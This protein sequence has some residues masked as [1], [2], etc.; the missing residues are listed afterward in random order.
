MAKKTLHDLD[1]SGK[2]VLLRVDFNVPVNSDREITDDNRIVA[3]LPTIEALLAKG[4]AVILV[5]HFG[6]PKG[7]PEDKY[8]LDVVAAKLGTLLKVPFI[9]CPEFVGDIA[10]QAAAELLPGQVLLLENSRFHP[11]EEKNAPELAKQLASYADIFVNDAFGAAHRAHATTVGVASYLPAVSGL[12][13]KRELDFLE[14]IMIKKPGHKTMAIIGG[15]KVSDKIAVLKNLLSL[16]DVLLI[17]GGMANTFLLSQGMEMGSSLVEPDCAGIA[18]EI[19]HLAE[20][21]HV[22]IVLPVDLIIA[23]EVKADSPVLIVNTEAGIP[24]TYKALDIGPASIQHFCSV[25]TEADTIVWN[26]PVGV[27]EIAEFATGSKEI[28]KT[29][30][31]SKAIT[32]IGGGDTAAAVSVA[33]YASSMSHVS[34]GGG[35]S[36][37][38][39]EGKELPGIAALLAQ[40]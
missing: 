22:R 37:E 34:T 13:M 38:F 17:G 10:A 11:G 5:S 23:E 31:Q 35:A 3:A 18:Q 36:L 12:L 40:N 14:P 26:G 19:M 2:K 33:G 24:A 39:L 21:K 30:A 9:Y 29:L 20:E 27:F 15:S 4:A 8:R 32:V 1:V 7:A 25:L 16:V 6:R 28:A